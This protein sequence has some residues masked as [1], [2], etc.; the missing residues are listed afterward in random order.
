MLISR[1]DGVVPSPAKRPADVAGEC[2]S[3]APHRTAVI[4]S[5]SPGFESASSAESP[6]LS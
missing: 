5:P 2:V 3:A 4:V 1:G 6:P